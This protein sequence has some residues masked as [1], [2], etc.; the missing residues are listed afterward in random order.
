[1]HDYNSSIVTFAHK[2]IIMEKRTQL[3]VGMSYGAIYGLGASVVT[4][5]FY[6]LGADLQSKIPQLL[7]YI[8]LITTIVYAIKNYRDKDLNGAISYGHALGTGVL[9]GLFGGIITAFFTVLLFTFIDPELIEKIIS[10][11]TEQMTEKGMTEEQMDMG[12]RMTR[13]FMTPGFLFI[14]AMIGSAFMSLIFSLIIA[15]IMKK[16]PNPFRNEL[17]A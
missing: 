13:K 7:G 2:Y 9:V 6:F 3:K 10:K 11:A 4:F 1:M 5:L 12:I 15:A 17:D 8:I 14:F 16:D